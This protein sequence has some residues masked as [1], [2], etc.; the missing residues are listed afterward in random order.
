MA[1]QHLPRTESFRLLQALAGSGR[2]YIDKAHV[3]GLMLNNFLL[4][5]WLFLKT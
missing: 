5:Y 2:F 1:Y 4:A 3:K